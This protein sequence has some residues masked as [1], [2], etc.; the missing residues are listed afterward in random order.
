MQLSGRIEEKSRR[1][2][3]GTAVLQNRVLSRSDRRDPVQ[4]GTGA[5]RGKP[6]ARRLWTGRSRRW[7]MVPHLGP[8]C[9]EEQP[10][11]RS[12]GGG[13]PTAKDPVREGPAG[14]QCQLFDVWSG[15]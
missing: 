3:K 14:P 13:H 1:K 7:A 15:I 11:I 8:G 4:G 2:R 9:R 10:W 5:K 12:S 6:R